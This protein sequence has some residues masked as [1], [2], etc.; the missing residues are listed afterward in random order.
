MRFINKLLGIDNLH[1]EIKALR[2]SALTTQITTLNTRVYPD[3]KSFKILEAYRLQDDLYSVVKYLSETAASIPVYGYNYTGEDLPDTSPFVKF[4]QSL[5]YKNRLILFNFLYLFDECFIYKNKVEFGPNAGVLGT[6]FL[7]PNFMTV[8]LTNDFPTK[9]AGYIYRDSRNGFEMNIPVEDVIF[10]RGVNPSD[11]FTTRWRGLSKITILTQTLTRLKAGKDA[12]VAQMQNGGIP[13]VIYDKGGDFNAIEKTGLRQ[14]NMLKYFTNPANKGLPY[15]AS[16]DMGY[17][18]LGLSLVDLD[19]A[20]L[21]KIDLKKICNTY[22]MSDRLLNN[23]ATGSE[24]SD[25]NARKSL[26]LNAVKPMTMLAQD[27]ITFDLQKEFKSTDQVKFDF[28]DIIELQEDMAKKMTAFAA[29]PTMVPN[30]VREA[31]GLDRIDDPL[32]EQVYL[33]TGYTP[34]DSFEPLPPVE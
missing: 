34:L 7:H 10:I 5:T 17:L 27:E 24:I 12:S 11:D 16:G 3:W 6:E 18:P 22:S 33:K 30:D 28:S 9:I 2:Q 15:Q 25:N 14:E 23:D 4:L 26:Y 13:G 1:A 21:G 8:V 19:V 31:Q 32:M 20:E 29:A